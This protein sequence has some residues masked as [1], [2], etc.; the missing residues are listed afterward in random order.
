LHCRGAIEKSEK[1]KGSHKGVRAACANQKQKGLKKGGRGEGM[2]RDGKG[3]S[4]HKRARKKRRRWRRGWF[5][6]VGGNIA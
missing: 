5:M 3:E 6:K 1:T 2:G 4:G